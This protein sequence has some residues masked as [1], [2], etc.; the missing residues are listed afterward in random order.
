[1]E[2]TYWAF[3]D[4]VAKH[5]GVK[6]GDGAIDYTTHKKLKVRVTDAN[7]DVEIKVESPTN[8]QYKYIAITIQKYGA[9]HN[10]RI[11]QKQSTYP[12]ESVYFKRTDELRDALDEH[13]C[14]LKVPNCRPN[15]GHIA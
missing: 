13:V 12:C 15:R 1:M 11:Y 6:F 4:E 7:S 8:G 3:V 14:K 10:L 5:L 2:E 9:W